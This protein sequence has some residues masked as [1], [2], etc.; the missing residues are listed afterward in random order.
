MASI[1]LR[2]WAKA[3]SAKYP[4]AVFRLTP[5][6]LQQ[7]DGAPAAGN[8]RAAVRTLG[9]DLSAHRS[10]PLTPTLL[11]EADEVF[12]MTSD[13]RASILEF[14]P[15]VAPRLRLFDLSGK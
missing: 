5:R 11:E 14:A 10:R 2:R 4:H 7:M 8:S 9:G 15:D 3:A 6:Q 1:I 12:V 13:Q